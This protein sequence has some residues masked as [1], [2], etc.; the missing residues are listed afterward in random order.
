MNV[1]SIGKELGINVFKAFPNFSYNDPFI[2]QTIDMFL[3]NLYRSMKYLLPRG[4]RDDDPH[5]CP[6][7]ISVF[8]TSHPLAAWAA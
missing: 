3:E 7:S 8:N 5:K 2:P 4:Q 1:A 6:R